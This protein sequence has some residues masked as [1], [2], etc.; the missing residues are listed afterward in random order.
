MGTGLG[1]SLCHTFVH[2]MGGEIS[3]ESK[4]GSGTTFRLS[5]RASA[6]TKAPIRLP[7]KLAVASGARARILI[8]DDEPLVTSALRRALGH[9]HA[10]FVERQRGSGLYVA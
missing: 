5:L 7:T 4:P 3:V 1:L 8:V 6:S 2:Q 10:G 9:E